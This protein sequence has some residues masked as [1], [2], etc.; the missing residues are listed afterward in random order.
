MRRAFFIWVPVALQAAN[1]A[2]WYDHTVVMDAVRPRLEREVPEPLAGTSWTDTLPDIPAHTKTRYVDF[3]ALLL[4][5][6]SAKLKSE[7]ALTMRELLRLGAEDPD[8][9]MDSELNDSA[10][11]NNDRNYMG[12][13]SGP[14]SQGFRHQYWPGWNWRKPIA[15]FQIPTRAMGQAPDRI[16]LLAS[17]ARERFRQGDLVWGTRLLGWTLHYIQDLTQP[18]HTAEV[19]TLRIVPWKSLLV[20]PPAAMY[21]SLKDEATR[22]ITNYHW[23][24]EG[25]VR[26]ALI[27][28][29][30]SPFQECIE[31]TGG[32]ILVKS[33]RELALEI[34]RRS[35][36]RAHAT[37]EG[38]LEFVGEGLKEPGVSIPLD[39]A[40][41]N[42]ED[43]LKNPKFSKAREKLNQAT[44][45]SL[46]LM[47]DA[48]VWIVRWVLAR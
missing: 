10:D 2:A 48:S 8:H 46:R 39:P 16:D 4:L 12:G 34:T 18:F 15:T 36:E 33:P 17:E 23:A 41:V 13:T 7:H 29:N 27:Q 21:P 20:W 37:G 1:A 11:P 42:N 25:Y 45:E 38:L 43:L 32:S 28:K 44:C 6:P 40:R 9:G 22:V 24:Y 5:N 47:A 26:H 31:K 35:I 30:D 3:A 14:S 19:P